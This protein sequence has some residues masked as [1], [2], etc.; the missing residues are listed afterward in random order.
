VTFAEVAS[1]PVV[2]K[3]F[4][5]QAFPWTARVARAAVPMPTGDAVTRVPTFAVPATF[6]KVATTFVVHK[7]FETHA[8]P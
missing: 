5:N 3:L 4:E 7:M 8:F 6:A 2:R 1:R